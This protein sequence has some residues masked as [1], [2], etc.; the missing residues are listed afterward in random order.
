[1][2]V[3]NI[4]PGGLDIAY[5]DQTASN[6]TAWL[7]ESTLCELSHVHFWMH[8]YIVRSERSIFKIVSYLGAPLLKIFMVVCQEKLALM[9]RFLW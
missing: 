7:L 9:S 4:G 3:L 6:G 5:C 1:M 2:K 8:Y